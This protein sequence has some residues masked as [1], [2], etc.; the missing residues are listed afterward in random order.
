[1]R[2]EAVNKLGYFAE[3][4]PLEQITTWIRAHTSRVKD[5]PQLRRVFRTQ[6]P[7]L[8]QPVFVHADCDGNGGVLD[9]CTE[10]DLHMMS[11]PAGSWISVLW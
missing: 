3:S 11:L 6:R 8:A 5:D 7:K 1:M 2:R 10:Q 9:I 4:E